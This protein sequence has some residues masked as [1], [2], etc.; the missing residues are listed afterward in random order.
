[1]ACGTPVIAGD[2]SAMRETLD[3]AGVLVDAGDSDGLRDALGEMLS[4]PTHRDAAA[5]RAVDRAA[6]FSPERCADLTVAAYRLALDA[7]GH[8]ARGRR[9]RTVEEVA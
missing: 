4:N 8:A 9:L 7:P 2:N 3:G 6:R 1:M 5:A